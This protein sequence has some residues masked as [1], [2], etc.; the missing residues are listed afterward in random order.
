MHQ[1]KM[2]DLEAGRSPV[3]EDH[4]VADE[5]EDLTEESEAATETNAEN[6]EDLLLSKQ[7]ENVNRLITE[8]K[9]REI[10]SLDLSRCGIRTLPDDLLDLRHLEVS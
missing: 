2:S 10:V 3:S 5:S 8:C 9:Q 7:I 4:D 6:Y 1:I